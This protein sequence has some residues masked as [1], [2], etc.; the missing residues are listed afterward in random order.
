MITLYTKKN[1]EKC[2]VIKDL[3]KKKKI[4][5]IEK[6]IESVEDLVELINAGVPL[7]EAPIVE[8]DG[9]FYTNRTGLL[10]AISE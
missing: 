4:K 2:K 1:C 5:Y 3:L 9:K 7:N 6:S 8:K 10:K